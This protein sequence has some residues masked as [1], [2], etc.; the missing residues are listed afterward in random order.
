MRI[1]KT[2]EKK[3]KLIDAKNASPLQ[4]GEEIYVKQKIVSSYPKNPDSPVL[5]TIK[6]INGDV[7]VIYEGEKRD[8]K[9]T[10][11]LFNITSEDI[12]SRY[13]YD[14]GIDP[15]DKSYEQIRPVAFTLDSILF[16]LNVM[17]EKNRSYTYEVKGHPVQE[18]NWNPFV[19]DKDGN[20]Q[21]YQRPFV[22]TRE[23]KQLLIE[24]IYQGNDCGKILI[25]KHSFAYLDKMGERGETELFFADLVDGK[26]RL[27]AIREFIEGEF[28]DFNGNYFSDLS[29][30]AQ[31][32][33]TNNQ[34]MSYAEMPEETTDENTIKQFLKLNFAGVPQSKE[35]IT[36][37]KEIMS[38][39]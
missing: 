4:V 33:F 19:F 20:K 26:Q 22:W 28:P 9:P 37:V 36:W 24:S 34:L 38:R 3:Q 23:D 6:E 14:V 39:I 35:H 13:L 1:N 25:R 7:I 10:K 8:Y 5:C 29:A 17:G 18:L 2:S 27:N 16:N 31:N 32:K 21:Y 11:Q 15:F 12:V 30:R